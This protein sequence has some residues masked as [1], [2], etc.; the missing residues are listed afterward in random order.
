MNLNVDDIHIPPDFFRFLRYE[1]L[2]QKSIDIYERILR[3]SV[4]PQ[5]LKKSG[6]FLWDITTVKEVEEIWRA[7][8]NRQEKAALG[9]Y[10]KDIKMDFCIIDGAMC[11]TSHK[12]VW[13]L[14]TP[15]ILYIFKQWLEK[16][17][18][19]D[20]PKAVDNCIKKI[21]HIAEIENMSIP[22]LVK[23]IQSVIINY[24]PG[25]RHEQ[26]LTDFCDYEKNIKHFYIFII[27][28]GKKLLINKLNAI[29]PNSNYELVKRNLDKWYNKYNNPYTKII[30][31]YYEYC[32]NHKGTLPNRYQ[33]EELCLQN[34]LKKGL[35]R[36]YLCYFCKSKT[37]TGKIFLERHK[38]SPL[39][40]L[41]QVKDLLDN[42]YN[43]VENTTKYM[44]Q[45]TNS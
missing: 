10:L 7:S 30:C 36:T 16:R 34:K 11:Y 25:G 33:L 2:D 24:L 21:I 39:K 3:K 20:N 40:I 17:R 12:E 27:S 38:G 18:Y 37:Q 8:H 19:P 41:P 15:Q 4:I 6:K 31:L 44:T 26:D 14:K 9:H 32:N 13:K 28:Y 42:F 5:I 23:H 45:I 43:K 29:K 22:E 35:V 1:G